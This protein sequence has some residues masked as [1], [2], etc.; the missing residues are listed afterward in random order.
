[1]A[2]IIAGIVIMAFGVVVLVISIVKLVKNPNAQADVVVSNNGRSA[3]VGGV[4][5]WIFL[6]I[7][8]VVLIIGLVT[9]IKSA[10]A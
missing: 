2:G 1:M 7:G 6:V 9:L 4:G 3:R 8:A 5:A 10:T